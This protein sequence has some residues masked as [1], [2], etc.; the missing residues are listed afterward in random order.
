[1][2]QFSIWVALVAEGFGA[3]LQHY[4]P[5]IDEDVKSTWDVPHGWV[6]KSQMV[7]GTPTGGPS[8]EVKE[9]IPVG[10]RYR[11]HGGE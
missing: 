7:F 4:N 11:V 2:A 10:E 8:P 1:M 9:F 3:N 6:L 5:V